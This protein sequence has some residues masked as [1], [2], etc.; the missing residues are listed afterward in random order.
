MTIVLQ[1]LDV[2]LRAGEWG[3]ANP[4][5]APLSAC[6]CE[7]VLQGCCL[8]GDSLHGVGGR[9]RAE[10]MLHQALP[11][12][13]LRD[14]LAHANCPPGLVC[15]Q[16]I[17]FLAECRNAPPACDTFAARARRT[18]IGQSEQHAETTRCCPEL[19]GMIQAYVAQSRCVE[20]LPLSILPRWATH[21]EP[22]TKYGRAH[23]S[24]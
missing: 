18:S 5:R 11:N 16:E 19:N 2:V 1:P 14:V 23:C 6:I 9:V 4:A 22:T 21:S 20:G 24:H 17:C 7:N 12:V 13:F 15:A 8:A 10:R 3:D